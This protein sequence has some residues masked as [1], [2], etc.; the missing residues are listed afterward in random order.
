MNFNPYF[1][2]GRKVFTSFTDWLDQMLLETD[3]TPTNQKYLRTI[4]DRSKSHCIKRAAIA[5]FLMAHKTL[6]VTHKPTFSPLTQADSVH[7]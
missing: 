6:A 7:K 5:N 2:Q 3:A 4:D 1:A